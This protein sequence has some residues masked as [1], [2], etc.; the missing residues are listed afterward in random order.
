MSLCIFVPNKFPTKRF[1]Y[2]SK[3]LTLDLGHLTRMTFRGNKIKT[4][5]ASPGTFAINYI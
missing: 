4:P 2:A 5:H 3:N 1:N